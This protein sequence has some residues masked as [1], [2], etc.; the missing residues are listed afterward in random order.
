MEDTVDSP[1][2]AIQ[3]RCRIGFALRFGIKVQKADGGRV[4]CILL[5]RMS[6]NDDFLGMSRIQPLYILSQRLSLLL[7]RRPLSRAGGF[8]PTAGQRFASVRRS[9]RRGGQSGGRG[10][11]YLRAAVARAVCEGLVSGKHWTPSRVAQTGRDALESLVFPM[12]A[13]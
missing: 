13:F 2:I 11:A 7:P 10:S 3:N 5:S 6:Q 4:S 1:L 12:L 8:S 9:H